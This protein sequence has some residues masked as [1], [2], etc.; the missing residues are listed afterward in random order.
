MLDGEEVKLAPRRKVVRR[1]VHA[2]P[3]KPPGSPVIATGHFQMGIE[4]QVT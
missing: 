2:R 1:G 3:D 4:V